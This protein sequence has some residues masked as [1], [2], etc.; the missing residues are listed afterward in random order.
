MKEHPVYET[1]FYDGDCGLCDRAV[2]FVLKRDRDG[3]AFRFA[4]LKGQTFQLRVLDA[5]DVEVPDSML[6]LTVDGSLLMR[7]SAWIHILRRLGSGWKLIAAIL[8]MIPTNIRDAAYDWV[9][10]V[11]YGI[12]GRRNDACPIAPPKV[13]SRFDP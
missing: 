11:R 1:I 6:V 10:A 3:T 7:S 8:K 12:F 4:P 9:A 13:A 2:R 5:R